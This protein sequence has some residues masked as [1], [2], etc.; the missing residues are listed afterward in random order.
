MWHTLQYLRH[1]KE[2]VNGLEPGRSLELTDVWK[3]R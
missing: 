1:V 3:I 2:R